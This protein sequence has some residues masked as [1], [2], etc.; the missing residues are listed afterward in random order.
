MAVLTFSLQAQDRVELPPYDV[1]GERVG[2]VPDETIDPHVFG[3]G[4]SLA[5]TPRAVTYLGKTLLDESGI[6][7]FERLATL[8][9]NLQMPASFGH[10]ATPNLRG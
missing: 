4:H 8:V 3:G 9:P 6:H 5:D 7:T 1:R 2:I 10:A